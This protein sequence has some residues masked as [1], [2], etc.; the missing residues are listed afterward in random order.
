MKTQVL[1]IV[2]S[3]REGEDALVESIEG[4]APLGDPARLG[5]EAVEYVC[6]RCGRAL[7]RRERPDRPPEGT[8]SASAVRRVLIECPDCEALNVLP[9]A[10]G[11][12]PL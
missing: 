7:W 12:D 5:P 6:G 4:D 3:R 9:S 11:G 1:D 10:G 2:D 8:G